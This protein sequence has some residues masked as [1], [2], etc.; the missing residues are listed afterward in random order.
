MSYDHW[1]TTEPD[2]G[3]DPPAND[4]GPPEPSLAVLEAFKRL[5]KET[6]LLIFDAKCAVFPNPDDPYECTPRARAYN[7]QGALDYA[8]SL[9]DAVH[10][11]RH[12]MGLKP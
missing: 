3:Y 7:L 1:L 5:E 8:H 10:E 12:A 9:V 11:L 4:D 2:P 6:S